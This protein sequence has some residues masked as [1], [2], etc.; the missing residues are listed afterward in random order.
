[1]HRD[2][3]EAL[4]K[5]SGFEFKFPLWQE[6]REAL[7]REFVNA[8]FKAKIKIIDTTKLDKKYLCL[9][10]QMSLLMNLNL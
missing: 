9:I 7:A 8:G 6:L 1:M 2:W 10:L 3:A 5:E 4:C